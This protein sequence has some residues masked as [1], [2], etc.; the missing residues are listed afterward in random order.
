MNINEVPQDPKDFKGGDKMK[1]LLY[2]VDKDG[3]YTS[4]NSAGWDAENTALRQA[5]DAV[6]DALEETVEKVKNDQVSPI[7][8]YMQKNLMDISLLAKY[9]GK[10]TWQVRRHMKPSVFR[11]LDKQMLEKY[12]GIFNITPQ[13]LTGF[14]K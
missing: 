10:W 9:A 6:D 13:E 7:A 12:A 11:K 14:G 5:W 1:K 2:A 8:Y 3:N 4:V